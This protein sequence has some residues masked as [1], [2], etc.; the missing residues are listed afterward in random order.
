MTP[1][2]NEFTNVTGLHT[3]ALGEPGNRTFRVLVNSGNSSSIIWLEKEQ[4]FQLA[5]AIQQL[6]AT[7]T[8]DK[9]A[10][11]ATP[12]G[13]EEP[14][15]THLDFKVS[16]LALGH[17]SSTGLF[18]IDAHDEEDEEVAA[19]RVWANG[20]QLKELSSEAFKVCA[21]GRPVCPLCAGPIDPTGHKCPRHNGHVNVKQL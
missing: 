16:K 10:S 6:I 7:I 13:Q 4:L 14:A 1:A 3:E 20:D 11:Q 17:N 19:V 18:V 5:I 12:T 8:D 21:A 2:K 9:N 15:P